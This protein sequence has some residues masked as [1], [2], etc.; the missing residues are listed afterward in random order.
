MKKKINIS[1]AKSVL[2][3]KSD[4]AVIG[5][6]GNTSKPIVAELLKYIT[7]ILEKNKLNYF[8]IRA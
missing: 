2:K 8:I 1:S 6:F 4:Q 5:I 7:D 3:S